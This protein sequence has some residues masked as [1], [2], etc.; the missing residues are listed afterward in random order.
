[1]SQELQNPHT[2][3]LEAVK[4]NAGLIIG[5]GVIL[6]LTGLLAMGSPFV[7]GLSVAMMVGIMLIVGGVGQ[8]VFAVK[9][10]NSVLAIILGVLTVLI[11]GYTVVTPAAA[12]ATLTL[13]LAAYLILSGIFEALMAWQIKP[14]KG[15]GWTMFSGV[16][17]VLLGIMIW[18]Q[19]PIS[20]VWAIGI[21]VGVK[22]FFSGWT[23]LML[24]LTTRS[25]AKD[26]AE[27]T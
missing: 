10:G 12:L 21:L 14:V 17:S 2:Q 9:S 7:A 3:F 16:V 4:Q 13:F 11:G 22:L 1:M 15:W 25:M 27:A 24:G 5:V 6:L 23:L 8:L 18:S 20:G 26:V 19:F